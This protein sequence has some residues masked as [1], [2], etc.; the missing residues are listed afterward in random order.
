MSLTA[1][2]DCWSKVVIGDVGLS[3]DMLYPM[4]VSALYGFDVAGGGGLSDGGG[5]RVPKA[6]TFHSGLGSCGSCTRGVDLGRRYFWELWCLGIRVWR[7]TQCWS[8]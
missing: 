1:G 5:G 8:C 2:D 3:D 7:K 4:T 6:C